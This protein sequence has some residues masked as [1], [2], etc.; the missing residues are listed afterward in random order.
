MPIKYRVTSTCALAEAPALAEFRSNIYLEK[1][2]FGGLI[3]FV[4]GH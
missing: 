1:I 4:L 3:G 2:N